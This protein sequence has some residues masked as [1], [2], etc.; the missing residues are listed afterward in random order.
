MKLD[1]WYIVNPCNLNFNILSGVGE[2]DIIGTLK[3]GD[4]FELLAEWKSFDGDEI[5][6]YS[7]IAKSGTKTLKGFIA[8]NTIARNRDC[9]EEV[10]EENNKTK[11]NADLAGGVMT[12]RGFVAA[13]IASLLTALAAFFV[14]LRYLLGF[15]GDIL[16]PIGEA[17][18]DGF[19][20]MAN[21]A[22]RRPFLFVAFLLALV[23]LLSRIYANLGRGK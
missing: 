3:S 18:I 16:R 11:K 1:T 19:V 6:G 15:L 21:Q 22:I 17:L 10:P 23:Y 5:E 2:T 8:F 13:L 9:I 4:T 20:W 14:F 12:K 7:A